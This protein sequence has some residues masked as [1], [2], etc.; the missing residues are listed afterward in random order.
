[1]DK[2]L[3]FL[4]IDLPILC[5][6]RN[7]NNENVP[8][9]GSL[10]SQSALARNLQERTKDLLVSKRGGVLQVSIFHPKW[11][12][13]VFRVRVRVGGGVVFDLVVETNNNFIASWF[14]SDG[15]DETKNWL[16]LVSLWV[17]VIIAP[18]HCEYSLP[19]DA[20]Q[21]SLQKQERVKLHISKYCGQIK[22]NCCHLLR[23]SAMYSVCEPMFR[24]NVSHLSSG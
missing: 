1:L 21:I 16:R 9:V 7:Q 24:R 3:K 19:F 5:Y 17:S 8:H 2:N 20:F 12:T 14:F 23:Y 6:P 15:W 11:L 22:E 10:Q 18:T 4:E 13:L